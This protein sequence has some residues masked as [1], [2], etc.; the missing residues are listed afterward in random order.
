MRGEVGEDTIATFSRRF[1]ISPMLKIKILYF[2]DT[3]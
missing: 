3:F 2:F 1:K